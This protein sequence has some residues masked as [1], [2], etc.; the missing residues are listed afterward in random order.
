MSSL[1]LRSRLTILT[2]SAVAIAV[3]LAALACW[4]I[5]RDQLINQLDSSLKAVRLD[6]RQVLDFAERCPQ[7]PQNGELAPSFY[8]V[9]LIATNGAVCTVTGPS[10]IPASA[11]DRAVAD[12]RQ[13]SSVHSAKANNGVRMRVVTYRVRTP[14]TSACS[15]SSPSPSP[16]RSAR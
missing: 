16:A 15:M 7:D 6:T 10:P 11:G 9:Q 14:T 3:A 4:L 2:A 1:P 5:T 13:Q 8:T 12:H